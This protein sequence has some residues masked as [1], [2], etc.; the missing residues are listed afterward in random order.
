MP[1]D[2]IILNSRFGNQGAVVRD[3]LVAAG[4]PKGHRRLLIP[5]GLYPARQ[6]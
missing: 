5:A 2:L 6:V 4:V 3:I 1:N